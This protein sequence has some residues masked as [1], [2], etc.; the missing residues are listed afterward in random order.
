MPG[1]VQ[2]LS[3]NWQTVGWHGEDAGHSQRDR[4]DTIFWIEHMR[5]NQKKTTSTAVDHH[6]GK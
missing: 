2:G 4:I 5:N 6:E 3:G 1:S